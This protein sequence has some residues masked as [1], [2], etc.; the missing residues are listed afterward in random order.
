MVYRRRW[1]SYALPLAGMIG[2][3]FPLRAP[4]AQGLRSGTTSVNLVVVKP[5]DEQESRVADLMVAFDPNRGHPPRF[6]RLVDSPQRVEVYTRDASGRLAR[7]D[8][9]WRAIPPFQ[10]G[11][12]TLRTRSQTGT[13]AGAI[14]VEFAADASDPATYRREAVSLVPRPLP[15]VP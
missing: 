13:R 6:V 2:A 4:A 9:G 12:I 11:S 1:A 10:S 15:R 3:L 14:V 5:H 7:L 8:A